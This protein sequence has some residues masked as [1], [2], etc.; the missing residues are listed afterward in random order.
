MWLSGYHLL[1]LDEG[2][3]DNFEDHPLLEVR[4]VLL[5][6]GYLGALTDILGELAGEHAAVRPI[7][8]LR[9]VIEYIGAPAA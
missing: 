2:V 4:H 5:S 8:L 9:D 7:H 3:L 6:K 1:R